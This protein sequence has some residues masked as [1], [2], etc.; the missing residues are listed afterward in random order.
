MRRFLAL[1]LLAAAVA[2][3][4]RGDPLPPLARTPQ[5]V[6]DL[7]LGQRG[8]E[9]EIRYAAPRTTTGGVRLDVHSVEV[10]TARGDGDFAKTALV[11]VRKV[12]PGEIVTVTAPLPPP[13]TRL[14]VAARAV[15]GGDRSPLTPVANLVV[16][17]PPAGP[18]DLKAVLTP[19]A[20]VLTW[21]GT[22]PSP[23]P[24]PA[25]SPSPVASPAPSP[26][27]SA[28][29]SPAAS[30]TPSP[31]AS[32]AGAHAPPRGAHGKPAAGAPGKPPAA[33]AP[34]PKP[35]TP[36]FR[37][38]RRDPVASYDAP[39]SA[40]PVTAHA[41]E[42]RT[43]GAGPRWCYVVRVA[44]STDPLVE[45]A[46]SNEVCVDI[47][48]V[49]PPAAPAGVATL[50]GEDAIEV[51]WSPSAEE[52]LAG[53]R[54]YRAA[55]GKP[56]ERLAEVQATET[57]WRDATPPHGGNFLYTVTAYDKSGNESAP[58]KPAEGHLP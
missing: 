34:P 25:P 12:A 56:P 23:P 41:F 53:Y 8:N 47:K 22:I 21:A 54:V 10:L 6:K 52:D 24:T 45:S 49:A 30:P 3:G 19:E 20:V 27:A 37:V 15:S 51:S 46:P 40:A 55:E 35:A 31:A 29:P 57:K 11:E 58:S 13:G 48:D 7:A 18:T 9:I 26:G 17:A 39:L 38:F 5:V 32:P 43:M 50:V 36:G 16:Q 2:C 44:A 42:D 28:A 14:R 33:A 4:K 1:V